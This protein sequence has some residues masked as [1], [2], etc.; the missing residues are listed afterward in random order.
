M[1]FSIELITYYFASSKFAF[2]SSNLLINLCFIT[3]LLHI[4]NKDC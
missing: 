2:I 3:K 1:F 4:Q